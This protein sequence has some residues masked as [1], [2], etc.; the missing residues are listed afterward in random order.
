MGSFPLSVFKTPK[1]LQIPSRET[2][3]VR[4]TV[5]A[6]WRMNDETEMHNTSSV[7]VDQHVHVTQ[8]LMVSTSVTP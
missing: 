7:T 3:I 4:V 8:T 1:S 2:R 6:T 5:D